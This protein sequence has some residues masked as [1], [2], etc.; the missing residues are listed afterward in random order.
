MDAFF[1]VTLRNGLGAEPIG[2]KELKLTD[3]REPSREEV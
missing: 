2:S 1:L 3:S